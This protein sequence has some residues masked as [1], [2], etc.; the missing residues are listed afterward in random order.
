MGTSAAFGS[1]ICL[2]MTTAQNS[3]PVI[4]AQPLSEDAF[5][6]AFFKLGSEALVVAGRKDIRIDL[7][8]ITVV[9][10]GCFD[11]EC[12]AAKAAIAFT[13][14][15]GQRNLYRGQAGVY[16]VFDK[17]TKTELRYA[18]PRVTFF[19]GTGRVPR[20]TQY[21]RF[22][23]WDANHQIAALPLCADDKAPIELAN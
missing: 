10:H 14:H 11:K 13:A 1:E 17:A 6:D 18:L 23:I 22:S 4:H 2:P 21:L 5:R 3:A 15:D 12:L 16:V 8:G 9:D 7:D 19:R 20:Y